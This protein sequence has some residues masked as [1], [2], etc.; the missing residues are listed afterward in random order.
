MQHTNSFTLKWQWKGHRGLSSGANLTSPPVELELTGI[1]GTRLLNEP[2]G[3]YD[4]MYGN[5]F[6]DIQMEKVANG[7]AG[8]FHFNENFIVT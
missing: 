8:F 7:Q 6:V 1:G 5:Q 2:I 4:S 3:A